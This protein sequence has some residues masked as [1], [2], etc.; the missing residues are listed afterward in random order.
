[1][2]DLGSFALIVYSFADNSS[3]RLKHHYFY[4]DPLA[5]QYNVGGVEFQ[6]TDGIFGVSLSKVDSDGY[7][8]QFFNYD[9]VINIYSFN[10][11][12]SFYFRIKR[13]FFHALSSTKEFE[14]PNKVLQNETWATNPQNFNDFKVFI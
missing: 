5:G 8:L 13:V 7:Y 3:W 4:F 1:M 10:M 2:P 12:I 11:V 6:W 14:V 9:L